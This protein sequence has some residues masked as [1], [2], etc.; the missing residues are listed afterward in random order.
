MGQG[1]KLYKPVRNGPIRKICSNLGYDPENPASF[2]A[3]RFRVSLHRQSFM[4]NSPQLT[5][6]STDPNDLQVKECVASYLEQNPTEFPGDQESITRNLA[7]LMCEQ[8]WNT[9]RN[10]RSKVLN[11]NAGQR[12]TNN[13]QMASI[14]MMTPSDFTNDDDDQCDNYNVWDVPH[15]PSMLTGSTISRGP[16]EEDSSSEYDEDIEKDTKDHLDWTFPFDVAESREG[17]WI[18]KS[19]P[20]GRCPDGNLPF[21]FRYIHEH[22][23]YTV[24]KERTMDIERFA[25][26]LMRHLGFKDYSLAWAFER[27]KNFIKNYSKKWLEWDL[28]IKREGQI[29]RT[30][31]FEAAFRA[32]QRHW[33]AEGR[34]HNDDE[35]PLMEDPVDVSSRKRSREISVQYP[36]NNN[37]ESTHFEDKE[38][39]LLEWDEWR[40]NRHP[41][42]AKRQ[43]TTRVS[44]QGGFDCDPSQMVDLTGDD[45]PNLKVENDTRHSI[46]NEASSR[47]YQ[48]PVAQMTAL[49]D[50]SS[51]P[52]SNYISPYAKNV[53]E[54]PLPLCSPFDTELPGPSKGNMRRE[55]NHS[56][57]SVDQSHQSSH[58]TEFT[59]PQ[60]PKPTPSMSLDP[61]G[62]DLPPSR[63]DN[64]QLPS[65]A[66]SS[67]TARFGQPATS[68]PPIPSSSTA[69]TSNTAE[70]LKSVPP[71]KTQ[72]PLIHAAAKTGKLHFLLQTSNGLADRTNP[73]SKGAL[74][75]LTI[76]ELFSLACDRSSQPLESVT[77]LTFR[78]QWGQLVDFELLKDEGEDGWETLKEDMEQ[79]YD[80]AKKRDVDLKR[81]QIWIES[82]KRAG[83]EDEED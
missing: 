73:I 43:K 9:Q 37:G 47:N 15:S 52:Q 16:Y 53:P 74:F 82:L 56:P 35:A 51:R 83:L 31:A 34:G 72:A 59:E 76:N 46:T 58:S 48:A 10:E 27:C 33:I 75:K 1:G 23:L 54:S 25:H 81:P 44:V 62:T 42:S 50:Q 19:G 61:S 17:D 8:E 12:A 69:T 39:E 79:D 41:L 60:A 68:I 14:E 29:K 2:H 36:S 49:P 24:G 40:L 21:L 65:P 13:S 5:K 3:F 67:D 64:S 70:G 20:E 30:T 78:Y 4:K 66:P 18:L 57:A 63:D 11:G 38:P 22:D 28:L 6:F 80:N 77:K 55:T 7:K 26:D 32:R 71:P 45:V